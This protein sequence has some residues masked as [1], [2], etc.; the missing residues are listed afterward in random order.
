MDTNRL[1]VAFATRYGAEGDRR[2]WSKHSHLGGRGA[3]GG[4]DGR[5]GVKP[6][7]GAGVGDGGAAA[8]RPRT[9]REAAKERH[10]A[11]EEARRAAGLA[12]EE[13]AQK[14]PKLAEFLELM[15]P[16]AARPIWAD[17]GDAA[18]E[19]AVAAGGAGGGD[20]GEGVG[21]GGGEGIG[22]GGDAGVP[23][24]ASSD[25]E[26]EDLSRA[27]RGG[28]RDELDEAALAAL[29]EAPL[30]PLVAAK[31]VS[32]MDYLKSR[33]KASFSDDNDDAAGT[34]DEDDEDA[35]FLRR[36][37]MHVDRGSEE[38]G[39]DDEDEDKNKK[40]KGRTK[41]ER[42]TVSA[43]I[44]P[45]AP[46]ASTTAPETSA[47]TPAD[48]PSSFSP[49][50]LP[51][52]PPSPRSSRPPLPDASVTGRLFVRNLP[53]GATEE[54]L[55]AFFEPYGSVEEVHLPLD[56]TT[57]KNRGF[58]LIGFVDP[59]DATK[60][61]AAA[62]A[63]PFQGRL[64]H[65]LPGRPK[66][67]P[68]ADEGEGGE[69]KGGNGSNGADAAEEERRRKG[70]YKAEAA[71]ARRA[72]AGSASD[73]KSWN[74]LY[75][76]PDAVAEAVAAHYGVTKADLFDP[77][78]GDPAVRMALGEAAVLAATKAALR[79]QG[80]RVSALERAAAQ[81]DADVVGKSRDA[82]LIKN[83]P[84]SVTEQELA[85]LLS[86]RG[87]LDRLILP[88]SRVLALARFAAPA[89]ARRAFKHLAYRK[90]G[91]A[92][93]Y[94]EW[95]PADVFLT[96]EEAAQEAAAGTATGAAKAAA[97]VKAAQ[98]A[99]TQRRAIAEA[100]FAAKKKA[101]AHD[102][103]DDDAD[104]ALGNDGDRALAGKTSSAAKG[105]ASASA[106]ATPATR[107][108][109]AA[110]VAAAQTAA[111]LEASAAV[112]LATPTL[113]VKN[114]AF[115][116]TDEGLR[117]AFEKLVLRAQ[118]EA[119]AEA[120]GKDGTAAAAKGS[121]PRPDPS[122]LRSARVARR[123]APR[124]EAPGKP[125]KMVSAGYGFVEV[126][127][128]ALASRVL[129]LAQGLTLD[130]HRLVVA[131]SDREGTSGGARTVAASTSSDGQ[132]KLLVKN[133]PFQA[134]RKELAALFGAFGDLKSVRL[135][136][137]F[138]GSHRGYAF[139]EYASMQEAQEALKGAGGTHLYGRRLVVD[140]A[141]DQ[142]LGLDEERERTAK[143]SRAEG[144]GAARGNGK[145]TRG[146]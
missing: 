132:P 138:D 8:S 115:A 46:G 58:A 116:T 125:P 1:E 15:R 43:A 92:P 113:F 96:A 107:S 26:Y 121:A 117:K 62:D 135:P 51:S 142:A 6:G 67:V 144:A 111:P 104:N 74:A 146:R 19:Q 143:R 99:E 10:A 64:L 72:G 60:A 20:G 36:A 97:E 124:P 45:G 3:P 31:D 105:A 75:A 112:D 70:N 27:S 84:Y 86:T 90:L 44:A 110:E 73:A 93:V 80:V 79:A 140:W 57:R 18:F 98:E 126:A 34:G 42:A 59:S 129:K 109:V 40:G 119:A 16:R 52:P 68:D 101:S 13:D 29:A 21:G 63:A 91:D 130:G 123:P 55:R 24:A 131:P 85:E 83:L 33:V 88:P 11:R 66:R 23:D 38:E 134:T 17:G 61:L 118:R 25:D 141:A 7:A 35:A 32:D 145:R 69:K 41:G 37:G 100:M 114:L 127:S 82:F 128:E 47:S 81:R 30:D 89:D 56:A 39:E 95:A 76:R 53:F 65:V 94:L 102:D 12:I 9:A 137:K 28:A 22:G 139:V 71:A 4:G 14:D 78:A 108:A 5:G 120:G 49:P 122:A 87:E 133:V 50:S 103:G 136:K 77:T 54:E 48:A 106:P 2:I